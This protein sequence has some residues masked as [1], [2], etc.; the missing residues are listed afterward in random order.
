MSRSIKRKSG[1]MPTSPDLRHISHGLEIPTESYSDQPYLVQ[2]DDGA[3]LCCV[4]TGPGEEGLDGQRVITM[5][6]TDCGKTW[7]EPLPLEPGDKRENSYA[8]MLKAPSGRVFIFYNH[9]TDNVRE[10]LRHDNHDVMKRVDS[11]GHFVFKF[12]DDHGVTWSDHR[13]DIPFRLFQCDRENVNGGKV[14]FF[15]NVGKAFVRQ[16]KAYVPLTKVGKMGDGFFA[17]SEGALLV[18]DNLLTEPDP[19]KAKWQTLPDGDFG[20]R[21]PPGG[22]PISEEHSFC[23]LSDGS[24]CAVYRTIDGH[25]VESYSRNGGH[26]WSEP[27][28][29][30]FSDGRLMKHPRAANFAWRCGNGRYLYWFHNHGGS[31][32]RAQHGN[33]DTGAYQN[34]NPV[35]LSAGIEM[36]TPTGREI[37]WSEPEVVLYDHD[38]MI[39]MSYPDLLEQDG[40]YY[41]TETQKDIARLHEIPADRLNAM[42]DTLAATLG[43]GPFDGPISEDKRLVHLSMSSGGALQRTVP[44]P[45]LPHFR[46]CDMH[47]ADYRGKDT[48]E[49]ISLETW[50]SLPDLQPGRVLLDNRDA[51]GRGFCLRTVMG[52]AVELTISDG[53]TENHWTCDSVLQAGHRH[54]LVVNIDGGP[55][56]I[57]FII[58]GRLCDGGDARQFGW[59]RFSPYLRH[60]NASDQLQ[61]SPEIDTLR[62]YGRCLSTAEAIR[63]FSIKSPVTTT[64]PETKLCR[65]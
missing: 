34:R 19:A 41:L 62:L 24:I 58:D 32:M 50:L 53:Q 43:H 36:D 17:Q 12:S 37:A 27:R 14:C 26:T 15:W 21:T 7:S 45:P 54:H 29:K 10:L 64:P 59:G 30:R 63:H 52:G 60:I 28:Y 61:V 25:P 55:R 5:R 51:A 4:T 40:K 47:A 9:N 3:W 46:E 44:L 6:S 56:L 38:P 13:Y 42:W 2:T 1:P 65:V 49:G 11:L 23:V 35:W 48:G 20:L 31:V 18:S 57:V 16:G 22:G 39:R 8:V 33:N